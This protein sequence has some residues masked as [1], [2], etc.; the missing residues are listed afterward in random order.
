MR[1][2]MS[3]KFDLVVL[4]GGP[5][6]YVPAIR[7]AQLGRKVALV[8]MEDMGGTC[9]NRG[10][11]PTKTLVA[12]ASLY[13]HAA[14]AKKFGLAGSLTFD[15][16][17]ISKRKEMI[18]SRLRKG[19]E[20]HLSHMGIEVIRG[21]GILKSADLISVDGI[22]VSAR[23]ILL[24]PGSVPIVPGFMQK[25][26]VLTSNEILEIDTLP[27]SLIIIGGGVIG[28]EFASIMASFG[29]KV[30]IVEMLPN[31]LPGV[32]AD[33]ADVV[34][35]SLKK[36]SVKIFKGQPASSVSVTGSE[37]SVTIG[38]GTVLT[39]G[40]LLAAIGRKS[41]TTGSGLLEVGVAMDVRGNIITDE[42]NLTSLP[43]VYAAGDATGKWQLA[44]AGSSQGIAAVH[45]MF[46]ASPRKVN[47]DAMSGCIFTFPEV[48]MVGPGEDEWK[49]RGVNVRTST[50]KYIANGK[51]MGLNETEGFIK[52]ICDEQEGT[53]IGVQ[54]VGADASSL[55]GW[56]VMAVNARIKATD[57][58]AF[59][60]PHPTLSELFMEASEGMGYGS[61][62]G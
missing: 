46:S 45:S 2:K 23:N 31:I 54:V 26:G 25:E 42:N 62:H 37:A 5:A 38:D 1:G 24:S 41:R 61:I 34:E 13:R 9:L 59:I 60:H 17:E 29:V 28:C 8:E 44:H 40:K 30:T 10:C 27:E 18:V 6:G 48:A 3:E 47:P 36:A 21:H 11:I 15:Y 53:I 33:V 56:A 14:M 19:I 7:A 39:A 20:A 50:A 12:S 52:L 4:G 58:A 16:A 57:A 55:I 51:A 49:A 35:K 43:N 22:P 32:D